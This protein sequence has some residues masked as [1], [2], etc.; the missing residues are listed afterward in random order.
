MQKDLKTRDSKSY[1]RA[2]VI[3]YFFFSPLFFS[4]RHHPSSLNPSL[5]PLERFLTFREPFNVSTTLRK[6]ER[7]ATLLRSREAG[8]KKLAKL[9]GG[10]IAPAFFGGGGGGGEGG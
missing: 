3:I 6:R 4:M 7:A 10:D 5:N 8:E 1:S 9:N 2:R